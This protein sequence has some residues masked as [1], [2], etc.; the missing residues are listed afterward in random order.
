[1][2]ALAL[3]LLLLLI[4]CGPHKKPLGPRARPDLHFAACKSWCPAKSRSASGHI[5]R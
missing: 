5:T 4:G 1:M 3:V 2:R